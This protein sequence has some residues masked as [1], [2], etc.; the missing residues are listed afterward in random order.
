MRSFLASCNSDKTQGR[1]NRQMTHSLCVP[2][3]PY[4]FLL[5]FLWTLFA[6]KSLELLFV[7]SIF[8]CCSISLYCVDTQ[9]SKRDAR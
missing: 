5:S 9:P 3:S 8:R 1:R 7:D 2:L 4:L 6:E